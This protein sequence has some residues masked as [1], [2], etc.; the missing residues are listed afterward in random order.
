MILDDILQ[1]RKA[2]TRREKAECPNAKVLA[3][4]I[5][6]PARGF[7]ENLR[8]GG[9]IAEVKKASPSKGV[10]AREF[11]P[12]KVAERYEKQGAAAISVLTEEHFFMGN[13]AYLSEIRQ[14]VQL[15]LLRKDFITEEFQ[16]YHA[17]VLGA[18]AVLLIAAIL[19]KEQMREFAD[20]ARSLSLGV[21]AETHNEREIE[22]ALDSGAEVIGINNRDLTTFEVDL[23][24]TEKLIKYIG[25]DRVIVSE[26]GIK[27]AEDIEYL[28]NLGVNA[29]L[30]GEA[31]MR[32]ELSL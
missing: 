13:N 9:I 26:S 2:Q 22:N 7:A 14:K 27:S 8:K 23:S 30:I 1:K 5:D 21:L 20:T 16:I 11:N 28:K 17:R 24:N 19:S 3:G 6:T 10:I 25:K 4:K 12:V 29:V 15:P 18:D 32:G 31:F